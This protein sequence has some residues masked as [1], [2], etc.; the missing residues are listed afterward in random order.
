MSF[1][2]PRGPVFSVTVSTVHHSGLQRPDPSLREL[3]NLNL[4]ELS[5]PT[6]GFGD[7]IFQP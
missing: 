5:E 4:I 7:I 6:F 2:R 3:L 1:S